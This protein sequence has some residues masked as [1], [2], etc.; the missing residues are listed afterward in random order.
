MTHDKKRQ[1]RGLRWVLPHAI[2]EVEI[3]ADVPSSVVKSVL[4]GLGTRNVT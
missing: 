3:A 2:G 1:G 4:S